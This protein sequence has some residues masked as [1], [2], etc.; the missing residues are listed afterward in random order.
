MKGPTGLIT[1]MDWVE[2]LDSDGT[3]TVMGGK[4]RG[5]QTG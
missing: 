3:G 1:G 5:T 4:Y 2:R